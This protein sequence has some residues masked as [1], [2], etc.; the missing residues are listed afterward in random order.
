MDGFVDP[1]AVVSLQDCKIHMPEGSAVFESRPKILHRN[2]FQEKFAAADAMKSQRS[3]MKKMLQQSQLSPQASQAQ[4]IRAELS[5]IGKDLT[6][7]PTHEMAIRSEE[8]LKHLNLHKRSNYLTVEASSLE[9]LGSPRDPR[10]A[11]GMG[12]FFSSSLD[13]DYTNASAMQIRARHHTDLSTMSKRT[14][15][16]AADVKKNQEFAAVKQKYTGPQST[17]LAE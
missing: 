15:V 13:G 4:T 9:K 12:G 3:R 1:N 5:R 6:D 2:P 7:A 10:A 16:S 8:N 17:L 11:A 14:L